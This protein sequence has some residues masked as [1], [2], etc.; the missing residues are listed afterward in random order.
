MTSQTLTLDG[1]PRALKV[2][3]LLSLFQKIKQINCHLNMFLRPGWRHAKINWPQQLWRHAKKFKSK[4]S[5]FFVY[6]TFRNFRGF[7]PLST[8][9]SWRVIVGCVLANILALRDLKV[10][11]VDKNSMIPL[12]VVLVSVQ[13]CA[14]WGATFLIGA[15]WGT[16]IFNLRAFKI[17]WTFV[18]DGIFIIIVN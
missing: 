3:F 13:G 9:I 2:R 6:K 16:I 5:Q 8:S 4:I 12:V 14:K 17:W 11:F 10:P 15:L 7:A 1:Q 18:H